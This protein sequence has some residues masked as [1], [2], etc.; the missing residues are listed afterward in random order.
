MHTKEKLIVLCPRCDGLGYISWE[1]RV[2][3]DEDET[4]YK[5]CPTCK[6]H[7]VLKKIVETTIEPVCL[8]EPD[9]N[10]LL[11]ELSKEC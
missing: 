6:G 10:D 7:R 11:D 4:R 3:N 2:S 1:E 8:N 5:I 9:L